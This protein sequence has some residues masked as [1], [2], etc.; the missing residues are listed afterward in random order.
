MGWCCRFAHVCLGHLR[1]PS[2]VWLS[3]GL[4]LTCIMHHRVI[5]GKIPTSDGPTNAFTI[6]S[7]RWVGKSS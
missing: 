1:I 5:L 3:P 4:L 2:T 6:I 7:G